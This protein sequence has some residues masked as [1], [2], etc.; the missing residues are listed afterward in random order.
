MSKRHLDLASSYGAEDLDTL[1]KEAAEA[2]L[3]SAE[4]A[5]SHSGAIP[6]VVTMPQQSA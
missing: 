3:K 1:L 2:R 6:N 4:Q 5:A